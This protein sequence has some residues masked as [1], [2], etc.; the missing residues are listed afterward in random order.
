MSGIYAVPNAEWHTARAVFVMCY[1][2]SSYCSNVFIRYD[3]Y[4]LRTLTTPNNYERN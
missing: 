3:E 2:V 4:I 1:R